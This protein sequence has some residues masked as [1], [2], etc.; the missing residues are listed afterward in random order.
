MV[1]AVNKTFW[2]DYLCWYD[3]LP[4]NLLY[5][6]VVICVGLNFEALIK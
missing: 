4:I 6:K 2:F 3:A 5:D 1:G